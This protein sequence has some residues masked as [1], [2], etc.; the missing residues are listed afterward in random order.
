MW[1]HIILNIKIYCFVVRTHSLGANNIMRSYTN[2]YTAGD[3]F[4]AKK[5]DRASM[6][7]R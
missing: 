7:M 6:S 1:K 2:Y 3:T 4:Y 5:N